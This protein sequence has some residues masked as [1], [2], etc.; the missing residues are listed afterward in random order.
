MSDGAAWCAVQASQLGLRGSGSRSAKAT[1]R[2]KR[3]SKVDIPFSH[4]AGSPRA[5]AVSQAHGAGSPRDLVARESLRSKIRG[6][7]HRSPRRAVSR[8]NSPRSGRNAGGTDFRGSRQAQS[9]AV[10]SP[11]R[12]TNRSRRTSVADGATPAPSFLMIGEE[13]ARSA[14]RTNAAIVADRAAI[15]AAEAEAKVARELAASS[16]LELARTKDALTEMVDTVRPLLAARLLRRRL[17]CNPST[18]AASELHASYIGNGGKC[19][20]LREFPQLGAVVDAIGEASAV[21]VEEY[22]YF[23]VTFGAEAIGMIVVISPS[24]GVVVGELR[25]GPHG[26]P[27][28][29]KACG[30]IQEGDTVVAVNERCLLPLISLEQ[31]S[32]EFSE[33]SRPVRVLFRRKISTLEL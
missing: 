9:A 16:S 8:S 10:P 11:T 30:R 27:L 17:S 22:Q 23:A 1:E 28:A 20:R 2:R 13:A 21:A 3:A 19:C 24:D 32:R 18:A 33:A 31:V 5:R 26:Q 6:S 25:H 4:K 29:A 7:P 14:E 12:S 15:V